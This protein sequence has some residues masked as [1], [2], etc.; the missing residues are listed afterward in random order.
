M[1]PARCF[2]TKPGYQPFVR[3]MATA[4]ND[5]IAAFR[6]A[7][8]IDLKLRIA[9]VYAS[10]IQAALLVLFT[11][12]VKPE[13]Q[14]PISHSLGFDSRY[15]CS[16]AFRGVRSGTQIGSEIGQRKFLRVRRCRLSVEIS[17]SR[18]HH[19]LRSN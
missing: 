14:T 9:I 1:A 8:T 16:R 18:R 10:K 12:R 6:D 17:R 4:A 3:A 11:A 5:A 15:D 13:R 19:R 2:E 7:A